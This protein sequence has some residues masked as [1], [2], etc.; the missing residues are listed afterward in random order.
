MIIFDNIPIVFEYV[1]FYSYAID[2]IHDDALKKFSQIYLNFK[3][4]IILIE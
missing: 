1:L 3:L 2:A 4:S